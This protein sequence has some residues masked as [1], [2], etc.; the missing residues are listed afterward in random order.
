MRFAAP[1]SL[2]VLS[3]WLVS[4]AHAQEFPAKPIRIIVGPGPDIVA[5]IFGQKF[6]EA[7]G[8]Q[9]IVE[10]RPGGGGTIA[11]ELVAKAPPDG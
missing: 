9:T 1:V 11:T 4:T 8:H 2:A 6:T 5:R 3:L 10:Q 7:W